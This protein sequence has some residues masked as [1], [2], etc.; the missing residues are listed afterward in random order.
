MTEAELFEAVLA[1]CQG[2]NL[3]AVPV[4]PERFANRLGASRGFVDLLIVGPGGVLFRELKTDAGT[5]PGRG[6]RPA[7]TIWKYRLQAAGL[8]W[9]LWQPKDLASGRIGA[10]LDRLEQPDE[11]TD[12]WSLVMARREQD[13]EGAGKSANLAA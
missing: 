6:L 1:L 4:K 10:E 2:R 7:Q 12:E 11:Y 8:D 3:W 13:C 9:G 5:Y